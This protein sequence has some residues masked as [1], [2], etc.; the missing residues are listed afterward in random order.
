M[1]VGAV[2]QARM[3]TPR[4]PGVALRRL[5]ETTLLEMLV[6]RLCHAKL[7]MQWG[8]LPS[9]SHSFGTSFLRSAVG[10]RMHSHRRNLAGHTDLDSNGLRQRA[11]TFASTNQAATWHNG[12][13]QINASIEARPPICVVASSASS[14]D[15]IEAYCRHRQWTFLRTDS[16]DVHEQLAEAAEHCG[17]D[18]VL[19]A[20]T[21]SPFLDPE[22]VDQALRLFIA[23][24]VDA[25]TNAAQPGFPHGQMVAAFRTAQLTFD[26][27]EAARST[28][29]TNLHSDRIDFTR[30]IRF[31]A[32]RDFSHVQ[33]AVECEEDF[34]AASALC[35]AFSKPAWMYGW[36]ELAQ[37][38]MA[39]SKTSVAQRPVA[40]GKAAA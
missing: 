36:R 10:E 26:L 16:V 19:Q 25:V 13:W 18:G 8:T 29:H 21:R 38:R 33:L 35:R 37:R 30:L 7:L 2:I 40:F 34:R 11:A 31:K 17:W 9:T 15:P 22:L 6:D 5:G 28:S 24:D 32:E 20:N 14:D 27:V 12:A 23:H 3:S 4:C 1:N 39:L